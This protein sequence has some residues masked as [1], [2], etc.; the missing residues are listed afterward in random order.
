MKK[1]SVSKKSEWLKELSV[2]KKS[3]MLKEISVTNKSDMLKDLPVTF[4]LPYH[5]KKLKK[6]KT[7]TW[8]A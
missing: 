3:D 1:L 5:A 6:K 7:A 4:L 8:E 2:N